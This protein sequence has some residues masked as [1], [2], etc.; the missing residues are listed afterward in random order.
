MDRF[1]Q[2]LYRAPGSEQHHG[3]S[4]ETKVVHGDEALAEALDAGWHEGTDA[5]RAAYA[6]TQ[7]VPPA[8][9]AEDDNKPATRAELEQKATELGIRFDG[10]TTDRKLGD[11]IAAKA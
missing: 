7:A 6:A 11:L 9:P 10:R 8:P 1:P 3:G 2:M 5:A 4:F